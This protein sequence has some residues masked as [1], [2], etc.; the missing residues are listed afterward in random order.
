MQKYKLNKYKIQ[1]IELQKY[2]FQK[3]ELS[4]S[5][6]LTFPLTFMHS[7][8]NVNYGWLEIWVTFKLWVIFLN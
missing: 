7:L 1:I 6:I 3:L 8:S 4:V 5:F 2:K